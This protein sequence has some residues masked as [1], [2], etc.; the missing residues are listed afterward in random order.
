MTYGLN[1]Q[2]YDA[3]KLIDAIWELSEPNKTT[4]LSVLELVV[5]AEDDTN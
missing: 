1:V 4:E 3:I 2:T 5:A